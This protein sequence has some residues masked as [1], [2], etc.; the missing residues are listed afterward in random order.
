MK[1][2][3]YK[4]NDLKKIDIEKFK[5]G[6]PSLKNVNKSE[7]LVHWLIERIE[8]LIEKGEIFYGQ[9]LP[10]KAELAYTF[11]VSLGTIQ[12]VLR[13]LEDKNYIYSKQCIGSIIK[14]RN[15]ADLN[16]R[17]K[18]SKKD[19]A[20]EKIK[21]YIKTNNLTTGDKLPVS[22][23]LG[24][25]INMSLNTVRNAIITLIA[26]GILEYNSEK[27]LIVKNSEFVYN[28]EID[29][30]SLVKKVKDDLKSYICENFKVG[31]KFLSHSEL[32]KIFNVSMKTIHSAIQILVKEGMLLPRRGTYGTTVINTSQNSAFEPR[33]EMS[34]FAPA[35]ETAFYHYQKI[36]NRIKNI[37]LQNY[38]IGSKLPSIKEFSE[39]LDVS[40]N[41]I[42]KAL[43]NLGKQGI[44]HFAR[45]RYGGTYVINMPDTSEQ[46][47][48]WL[49]VSP[50][51][52]LSDIKAN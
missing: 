6:L 7:A 38:D 10:K 43:S 40:P 3:N 44:L 31:D 29:E 16:L 8:N 52:T 42:R 4:K 51:Y 20:E 46:T 35:K 30:E 23:Q 34:I 17:K 1:Y 27:E 39:F 37:I 24:R 41:I 25:D 28:T 2:I 13:I 32:S 33:R 22:R 11:G 18:T 45:G 36:Q 47:F 15:E 49:A 26:D 12:N 21:N 5:T 14:D 50:Q 19:L 9:L 48:K